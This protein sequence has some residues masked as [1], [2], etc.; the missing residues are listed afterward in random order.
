MLM[1]FESGVSMNNKM[2]GI[3]FII[4]GVVLAMGGCNIYDAASAQ[5][6]RALN[7]ETPIEA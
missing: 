2:F 1:S 5:L 6:S 4:V 7:G 3:V